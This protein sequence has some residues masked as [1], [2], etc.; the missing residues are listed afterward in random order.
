VTASVD[1]AKGTL[2]LKLGEIVLNEA[3]ADDGFAQKGEIQLGKITLT[4]Q[5]LVRTGSL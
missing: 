5:R 3:L 1:G 2:Q 4:L